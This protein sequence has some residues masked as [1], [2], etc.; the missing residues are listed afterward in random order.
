MS[1]T[2]DKKSLV[3][4]LFK[5]GAHFGFKKSRRH[6]T[7]APYLFTTKDGSDIFDLE[8]T[9]E[10]LTTA[11]EVLS[12]AGTR[13]KTVLF[14][15]TKDEVS[16]LVK[17]AAERAEM[18]YVTNRWI[19]GMMTNFPEIKKRI[20]RL[21]ALNHENT[22][23]ELE[24][25]YTKKERVVIGREMDK[26]NYNFAGIAN[27]AKLPDLVLVVDPRHDH[28][29]VT[30]AISARVPVMA[31]M[32]SD[33][34]AAKVDYPVVAN[35]SLQAS[36]AVLLEELTEAFIEGKKAYVPPPAKTTARTTTRRNA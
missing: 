22:S 11:K 4:R 30:E 5:A 35:D 27:M 12:E 16:V 7:V 21:E 36:V 24:R 34:D 23:G 3:E 17:E 14:I 26:L 13:G 28:V 31:I 10:L 20:N 1:T 2:Q 29:A 18:P 6:P 25:K 15:A 33:C 19:G 32:S 9:T 8:K